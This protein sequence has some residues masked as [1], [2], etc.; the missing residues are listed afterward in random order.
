MLRILAK[1][2]MYSARGCTGDN[3]T[4]EFG[5]ATVIALRNHIDFQ[6]DGSTVQTFSWSVNAYTPGAGMYIAY[7]PAFS[8]GATSVPGTPR[9]VRHDVTF[10]D[11]WGW[12][13]DSW[14]D[15]YGYGS[16]SCSFTFY[17]QGIVPFGGGTN[18]TLTYDY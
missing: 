2:L 18:A 7:G 13:D 6:Y 8:G 17:K 4:Y 16:G 14:N 1:P 10:N 3:W 15:L 9:N 11:T 12:Y 5:G